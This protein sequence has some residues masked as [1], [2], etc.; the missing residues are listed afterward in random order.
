MLHHEKEALDS[1]LLA[2]T[3]LQP[4]EKQPIVLWCRLGAPEGKLSVVS[5]SYSA[6]PPVGAVVELDTWEG[7]RTWRVADVIYQPSNG[8]VRVLVILKFMREGWRSEDAVA[9]SHQKEQSLLEKQ[10][11]DALERIIHDDGVAARIDALA[12]LRAAGRLT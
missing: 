7:K 1:M 8:A 4:T 2:T 9:G 3:G 12:A 11:A 5:A 10:L 6:V